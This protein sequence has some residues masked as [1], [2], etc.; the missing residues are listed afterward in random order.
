MIQGIP[1]QIQEVPGTTN[2][3]VFQDMNRWMKG[4]LEGGRDHK[5]AKA[6]KDHIDG[7][8]LLGFPR[9][10]LLKFLANRIRFPDVS[11]E[12]N[13]LVGRINCFQHRIVEITSIRE[14][15][16]GILAD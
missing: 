11:F 10:M 4:G 2:A 1:T 3:T 7:N 14:Q 12:I 5:V 15:L 6:V 16:D 9:E 8:P 13:T